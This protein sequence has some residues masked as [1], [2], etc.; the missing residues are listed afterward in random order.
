MLFLPLNF[1]LQYIFQLLILSLR[2]LKRIPIRQE[3]IFIQASRN[4][5]LTRVK[6]LLRKIEI[7]IKVLL[8]DIFRLDLIILMQ[9]F[10]KV[11]RHAFWYVIIVDSLCKLEVLWRGNLTW[12]GLINRCQIL[13]NANRVIELIVHTETAHMVLRLYIS[14]LAEIEILEEDEQ[15]ISRHQY[16]TDGQ[17]LG[18]HSMSQFQNINK[19]DLS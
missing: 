18:Q 8:I 5:I 9:I 13:P 3:L 15:Q 4:I 1:M 14:W 2:C 11:L 19:L 17:D 7:T 10:L 6:L 16:R 12:S